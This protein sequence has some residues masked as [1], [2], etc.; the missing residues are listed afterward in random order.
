MQPRHCARAAAA[1]Q[2][3]RRGAR[4]QSPASRPSRPWRRSSRQGAAARRQ[5]HGG[6]RARAERRRRA[7]DGRRRR[8][9]VSGRRAA[10]ADAGSACAARTAS[11]TRAACTARGPRTARTASPAR[12]AGIA[13]TGTGFRSPR[14]DA[15]HR[16]AAV[17]GRPRRIDSDRH[18]A[19]RAPAGGAHSACSAAAGHHVDVP[20]D[21]G[22]EL[23]ETRFSAPPPAGRSP[24]P[25]R[26][27]R[28]RPPRVEI[29]ERAARNHRDPQGVFAAND[30]TKAACRP[31]LQGVDVRVRPFFSVPQRASDWCGA[32][33]RSLAIFRTSAVLACSIRSSTRS[34]ASGPKL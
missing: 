32:Y 21:S 16:P 34:N 6:G 15:L 18:Q 5:C 11:A 22:L 4:G 3:G 25:P 13:R 1:R 28:V 29:A 7:V 2:P 30:L 9:D 12:A 19:D 20:P 27:K 17:R 26:P 23:V 14:D 24:K 8:C 10:S 31:Q 33:G